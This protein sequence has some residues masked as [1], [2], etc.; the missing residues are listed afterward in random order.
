MRDCPKETE[1]DDERDGEKGGELICRLVK[2]KMGGRNARTKGITDESSDVLRIEKLL[3]DGV[4]QQISWL[5][6]GG[7]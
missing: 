5:N 1:G 2:G 3:D 7:C 4:F 6:I